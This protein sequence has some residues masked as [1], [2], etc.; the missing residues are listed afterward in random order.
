MPDPAVGGATRLVLLRHGQTPLSVDRRYSGRADVPM[1]PVGVD[2]AARAAA[3]LANWPVAAIISSPLQRTLQTAAPLAAAAGLPVVIDERLVE[4]DFGQ[5]EGLTFAEAARRDPELHREW[6]GDITVAPPG[7]ES[8]AAAAA[9]VASARA[10][11]VAEHPGRTV[12]LVSHVTPIKS[13]L[14]EAM[15]VGP[16]LLFGLHLD[17]ASIS[18]VEYF[19]DG[20]SVGRLVN[21]T[22]HLRSYPLG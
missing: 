9:R 13:V 16:E 17:L 2:Q 7:G 11:I 21:D 18:L 14:R 22:S 5:W 6:L 19:A 3:R 12:L 10:A 15:G 1:T 20:G 8:F 4:T